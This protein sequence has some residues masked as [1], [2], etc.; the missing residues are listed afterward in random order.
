MIKSNDTTLYMLE[1]SKLYVSAGVYFDSH[2]N[3]PL[4]TCGET[5]DVKLS[6]VL[7][8]QIEVYRGINMNFVLFLN[9]QILLFMITSNGLPQPFK[10]CANILFRTLH[11]TRIRNVG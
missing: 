8:T 4:E 11:K 7:L 9:F 2:H 1:K 10:T 6:I 5:H 3:K